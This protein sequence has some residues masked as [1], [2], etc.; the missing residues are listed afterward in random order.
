MTDDKSTPEP[1]AADLEEA[2]QARALA[3]AMEGSGA[4]APP[5]QELLVAAQI[6]AVREPGQL[7]D[8]ARDRIGDELF[9]VSGARARVRLPRWPIAAAAGLVLAGGL[10]AI[11]AVELP[12]L[13]DGRER[14]AFHRQAELLVAELMP[15]PTAAERAQAIADAAAARLREGAP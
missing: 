2:R 12:R 9:G 1:E 14:V 10:A 3:E 15:R 6:S 4:D 8:A 11:V 5:D 7:S 13:G